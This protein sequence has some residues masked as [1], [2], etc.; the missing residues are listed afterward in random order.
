MYTKTKR[1]SLKAEYM[2]VVRH[3]M[4]AELISKFYAFS[5]A[6]RQK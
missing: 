4:G 1:I 5:L 3:K 2:R 6:L